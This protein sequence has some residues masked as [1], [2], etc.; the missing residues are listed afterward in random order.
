MAQSASST[1]SVRDGLLFTAAL[2]L[3]FVAASI[4]DRWMFHHFAYRSVYDHGWGNMLRLVG[5]VPLWLLVALALVLHDHTPG[6]S[7]RDSGRR[8]LLV[9]GCPALA[10]IA[11]NILK[12]V[13]RR[14]RPYVTDGVHVFRSWFDQPFSTAQ[15]G[16]PS[17]ETA[18]AFA[19]GAVLARLFPEARILWYVLAAGCGLT[20]VANGAHFMSDVVLAAFVGYAVAVA[21]WRRSPL[22]RTPEGR[23]LTG[24]TAA[25][26]RP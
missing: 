7:L 11:A 22:D 12:L 14:E 5:Y 26:D 9:F 18:V 20:R 25:P 8:G 3:L 23:A 4:T 10:G 19:A 15:L 17:G 16:L 13:L 2:A 6:I 1:R 24:R 21:A